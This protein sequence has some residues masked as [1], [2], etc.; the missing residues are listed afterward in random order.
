MS[1]RPAPDRLVGALAERCAPR[2]KPLL[3]TIYGDSIL[4]LGGGA[5][6]AAVIR[7]GGALGLS[8]RMVRTAVFRL[9]HDG[10][11]LAERHG[12][13]SFYCLG[14][15][16]RRQFEAAERRIYAIPSDDQ[17]GRWTVAILAGDIAPAARRALVRELGWAGFAAFAPDLLAA[18]GRRVGPLAEAVAASGL[19]RRVLRLE[20]SALPGAEADALRRIVADHWSL[21]RLRDRYEEFLRVFSGTADALALIGGELSGEQAFVLRSLLVDS[22]RR[23]L[24]RDPALP[25]PLLPPDWPGR[26][27]ALL[28]RDIWRVV[29][30]PAE[31]FVREMLGTAGQPRTDGFRR[32]ASSACAAGTENPP[33]VKPAS[34]QGEA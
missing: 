17:D 8:E 29:N 32:F 34:R 11:L 33:G 3:A 19:D 27:A 21:D 15:G 30:A 6:L 7:L 26:T 2:A 4:P 23:I 5:W 18:P 22:Y 9:R 31:S 20:A 16:A 13:R 14:P 12:R 1:G 10:W 28:T 25:M 24:L